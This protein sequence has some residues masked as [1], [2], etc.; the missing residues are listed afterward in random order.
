MWLFSLFPQTTQR[1]IEDH[2]PLVED[3][4][5]TGHELMD[6]CTEEDA[7]DLKEDIDNVTSKLEEVKAAV[8]EKL[9]QLD[10]AFRSVTTDVS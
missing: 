8:R 3:L 7:S 6:L 1:I 5:N 10:D 9:H 4:V 2:K